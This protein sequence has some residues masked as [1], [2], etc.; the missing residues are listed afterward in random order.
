V[1]RWT[2]KLVFPSGGAASSRAPAATLCP[3]AR[4]DATPPKPAPTRLSVSGGAASSRAPAATLC[5]SARQDAAPP[6]PVPTRLSV[7]GGAASSRAPTPAPSSSARQDAAPPEG[8]ATT[9]LDT[10]PPATRFISDSP[11]L[12]TRHHLPHWEQSG[13]TCFV[14][15]RLADSLPAAKLEELRDARARWLATHPSPLSPP[16]AA[17]Y[18]ARF[19]ETAE[20]WLDAGHGE[21]LLRH[22]AARRAVEDAIRHFDG[23]RYTLHAF[24]VMPNHVHVLFTPVPGVAI[25]KILHSWKSFSAKAVNAALGRTGTVWKK[26]SWDRFIRNRRHFDRTLD[27]IRANP[28]GLSIPVCVAPAILAWLASVTA[29]QDASPPTPS[30]MR[31]SPSGGAAFSRAPLASL[32]PQPTIS[33]LNPNF[34]HNLGESDPL[35]TAS[36]SP[37]GHSLAARQDAAPPNPCP[38]HLSPSGGAASSRAPLAHPFTARQDAAPPKMFSHRKATPTPMRKR[39]P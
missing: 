28:G 22:P 15:F 36:L 13:T 4:Q 21:C 3:S 5:P 26:E 16:D 10:L 35:P 29:R 38:A 33:Q 8:F 19:E 11:I 30:P 27:Y 39:L 7:S 31:L 9:S 12:Q 34:P 6:K 14:T 17:E 20:R 23:L 18:R 1:T 2:S 32:S 24:V 25:A 37:D